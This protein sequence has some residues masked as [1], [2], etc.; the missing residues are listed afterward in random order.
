[1]STKTQ[2]QV[3]ELWYREPLVYTIDGEEFD[4]WYHCFV[5]FM[6]EGESFDDIDESHEYDELVGGSLVPSVVDLNYEPIVDED[7]EEVEFDDIQHSGEFE[8]FIG[9]QDGKP[10][11]DIS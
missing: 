5:R 9:D 8:F 4:G 1:M 11:G 7:F 3:R 2:T 10:T 6:E